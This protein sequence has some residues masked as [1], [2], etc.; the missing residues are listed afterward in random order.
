MVFSLSKK[1]KNWSINKN[2]KHFVQ[3]QKEGP[4]KKKKKIACCRFSR[5]IF[6]NYNVV[7]L[8]CYLFA[9]T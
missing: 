4:L 8:N 7:L 2:K 9:G 5:E 1:K 3:L 6:N